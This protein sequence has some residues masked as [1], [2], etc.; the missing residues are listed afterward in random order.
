MSEYEYDLIVIGA[1]PGGYVSAIRASQLGLKTAIIEK[2]KPGGVCLNIGC[3]P[4]KALI[5]EASKFELIADLEEMGL[6]IDKANFD[7]KKVYEK[8]RKAADTLSKGVNFLIKKNN[9][10]YIQD[11]ASMLSQHEV[12]LDSGKI[13][14]GKF[15]LLAT[16]SRP[17]EIPILKID[18]KQILSSTGFL[19]QQ[20]LPESMIILGAG[21]IG[22]ECAYIMSCFGVKVTMIEMQDRILPLEDEEVSRTLNKIFQKRGIEIFTASK[23]NSVE[24]KSG[25]IEVTVE[26]G[27]QAFTVKA[28]RLLV[29]V[30]RKPN[31][32]D[33]GLDKIGVKTENGFVQVG[34]Y[35]ETSVSA[36]FAIGD[37]IPTP[38]L[39]HLASKEGEIAV[40]HIAGQQSAKGF[41]NNLVPSAIY[42]EPQIASFGLTEKTAKEK[43]L[44]VIIKSFPY[45]GA[46]KS[47]AIEK[48]EGFV[49]IIAH[50]KSGEILGAHIIGAEATELIHEILLAKKAELLPEDIAT[51]VHA[52]PTLSEAVMEAMRAVEGWAIHA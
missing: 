3:I 6:K 38:Q 11:R 29:A 9:I 33:L 47:V 15:I 1:G 46:G 31:T 35:Y 25:K 22:I 24:K 39:A 37:I 42:S 26:S 19:Y 30:G 50:K 41:D 12:K 44:D 52:H 2:D 10:S 16:G 14:K 17:A 27:G 20:D 45:R 7:Y 4:S 36:I 34:D 51:M 8:S 21:A 5:N 40:E 48:T 43:K 28:E 13:I 32:E 18:E 49:K 23:A